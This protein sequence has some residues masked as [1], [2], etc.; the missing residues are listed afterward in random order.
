MKTIQ[1]YG[2]LTADPV[3]SMTNNGKEVCN[4]SVAVNER[5]IKDTASF[6]NLVAFGKIAVLVS[7]YLKKGSPVLVSGDVRQEHW[8]DKTTGQKRSAYKVYVDSLYLLPRENGGRP[9]DAP[10]T[11]P[12]VDDSIID[13]NV[14]TQ[15]DMFP[16]NDNDP[17]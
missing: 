16:A 12:P 4:F 6:F 15:P 14:F 11:M 9:K 7:K 2:R 8:Q 1:L 17:F 10:E 3:F 5:F 13:S